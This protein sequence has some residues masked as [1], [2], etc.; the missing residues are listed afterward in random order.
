MDKF[1]HT[2][3]YKAHNGE[4]IGIVNRYEPVDSPKPSKSII[5][6]FNKNSKGNFKWGIP[7]NINNSRPLYGLETLK[8][9]STIYIVEGEKCAQAITLA[10]GYPCIT[11][12]GGCKN[13]KK[14]N[15]S[16]LSNFNKFILIPDNDDMGLT[17]MKDVYNSIKSNNSKAEFKILNLTGMKQKE[18]VCDWIISKINKEWNELEPLNNVLSSEELEE[19][20]KEF[21]FEVLKSKNIPYEWNEVI[22][23]NGLSCMSFDSFTNLNIQ[24]PEK[25]LSPWLTEQSLSMIYA[26]RD[27]GKTYFALNCAYALINRVVKG[28]HLKKKIFWIMLFTLK[29][30]KI[31]MNLKTVQSL[32]WFLKKI[33]AYLVKM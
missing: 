21:N 18:D 12:L 25:W 3:K 14:S 27:V 11:S 1:V 19:L 24:P 31:M 33:E 4:T 20:K 7:D 13:A 16:E 10:F 8:N 32:K 17:Y 30:P 29:D 28:A 15:W 5:P 23:S 6:L 2:W 9:N 26:N 22:G